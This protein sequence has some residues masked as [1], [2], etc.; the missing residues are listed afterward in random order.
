MRNMIHWD[1]VKDALRDKN[2]F[3]H[4]IRFF[5]PV[6]EHV[7]SAAAVGVDDLPGTCLDHL[8]SLVNKEGGLGLVLM[9]ALATWLY[10]I[11]RQVDGHKEERELIMQESRERDALDRGKIDLKVLTSR[12]DIVQRELDDVSASIKANTEHAVQLE[13]KLEVSKLMRHVTA[14]GHTI[15]SW[16]A[17]AGDEAILKLLL[18][19]GAHTAIGDDCVGWCATIIQVAFRRSLER[20]DS[21][22]TERSSQEKRERLKLDFVV[23][24]RIKSLANLIR[25]RLG[26]IRLSLAEAFFNGNSNVVT[27][28]DRSDVP[29]SQALNLF[30]LFCPPQGTIPRRDDDATSNDFLTTLIQGGQQCSHESDPRDCAHVASMKRGVDLLESFLRQKR[31]Q[32]EAKLSTRRTTLRTRHRNA[33]ASEL[34]AAIRRSDFPAAVRASERGNISPRLRGPPSRA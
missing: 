17:G 16:A 14:G 10:T 27:L 13:K 1:A 15:L 30:H 29:L 28:L 6:V 33:M 19:R 18:K 4:R 22:R 5:H 32:T 34:A 26:R 25:E 7:E 31:T 12:L 3:F 24:M 9:M 8:D 23:S 21:R 20:K 11:F 2:R